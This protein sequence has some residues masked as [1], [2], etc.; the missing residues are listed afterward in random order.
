MKKI[1][2]TVWDEFVYGGHLLS[3]GPV[4]I[5]LICQQIFKLPVEWKLLLGV[6]LITFSVHAF[7]RFH[8]LKED[9]SGTRIKRL[10]I[11]KRF[12]P[13]MIAVSILA[14]PFLFYQKSTTFL[15]FTLLVVVIGIGY[16]I[17]FK[18]LTKYITGFKSF[19]VAATYASITIFFA[20]YYNQPVSQIPVFLALFLFIF[21]RWFSATIFFDKK[22]REIDKENGLKT[23]AAVL[24]PKKFRNLLLTVNILAIL[25]LAYGIIYGLLPTYTIVLFAVPIYGYW[26][27]KM[28]D[29][30]RIDIHTLCNVF[31]D[32]EPFIWGILILLGRMLWG[33]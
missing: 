23:I 30:N 27:I 22:D 29:N 16:S 10:N 24:S 33:L 21:C 18:K 25:P 6:Y 19:Y 5:V 26:Y 9:T 13:V 3:L 1:L 31:V 7:D 2:K 14:L 8:D 32:G 20:L 4:I 12:I 28:S 17:F 15:I 11:Y